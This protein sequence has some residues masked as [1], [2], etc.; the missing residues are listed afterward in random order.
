MSVT[1]IAQPTPNPNAMKFTVSRHLTDGS[2]RT[3]GSAQEAA[4][5]PLA[6]RLFAVPGVKT[7]FVLNDFVTVTK[8]TGASWAEVSPAAEEAL[9]AYFAA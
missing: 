5:D 3:Y 6:S 2:S 9:R 4:G 1:I 8:E 7:V